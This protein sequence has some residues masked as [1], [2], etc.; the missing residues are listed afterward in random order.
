[1]GYYDVRNC[2]RV[3]SQ[4][5]AAARPFLFRSIVLDKP[6][7]L[8]GLASL[9]QEDPNIARWI[10]KI[11]L[12]GVTEP[13]YPFGDRQPDNVDEDHDSWLYPFPLSF[14]EPLPSLK[15]LELQELAVVSRRRE[16]CEAFARWLPGLATL[17][18]VER[19]SLSSCE[20]S[21][22][23]VTAM[24]R[25][26]PSLIDLEFYLVDFSRPNIGVLA[27][28]PFM[29]THSS[30]SIETVEG[31]SSDGTPQSAAIEYPLIHPPPSLQSLRATNNQIH[32]FD[33]NTLRD[34]LCPK[35]LSR[36]LRTLTTGYQ[37]N[38]KSLATFITNLGVSPKLS[39]LQL[40]I[41]WYRRFC[42]FFP[43]T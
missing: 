36:S 8:T 40:H 23:S 13:L 11:V 4:W 3:C 19:M 24:L 22:N 26:F 27:D 35:T 39:H 18:T 12:R 33:F 2:S 31:S 17:T 6:K 37:V 32:L 21:S 15:I 20:M 9:I 5:Y 42:K 28:K 7:R 43:V 25:A 34:C 29:H 38:M 30:D 14:G 1:M 10:R 16:D 41:G